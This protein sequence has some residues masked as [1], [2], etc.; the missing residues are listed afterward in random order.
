[1]QEFG[2]SFCILFINV[3]RQKYLLWVAL[4]P[5]PQLRLPRRFGARLMLLQDLRAMHDVA[6]DLTG[7]AII[8][9]AALF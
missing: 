6:S 5:S 3:R 8:A 2:G 7:L 9:L 4:K 1:M